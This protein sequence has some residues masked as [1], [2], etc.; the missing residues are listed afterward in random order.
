MLRWILRGLLVFALLLAAVAT[1]F[2]LASERRIQARQSVT[3]QPV[4]VPVDTL[5]IEKGRH[6]ATIRGC[7][8]CHSSDLGGRTFIDSP[9][10]GRISGTNLTRGKGGVGGTLQ[11][12]DWV[13]AIRHG[14]APDGRVLLIMPSHEYNV[15][16]DEDAGA[17]IAYLK[18]VP[19]VDRTLPDNSIALPLR[20]I[21]TVDA[22]VAL[23]PA[24]RIDHAIKPAQKIDPQD[25]IGF[26]KYLSSSCTGC[27][28]ADFSGGK[29]P[30]APPDWIAAANLTPGGNLKNW[31]LAQFSS[32][33]RTGKTPEGHQLDAHYMP[34][35]LLGQM[36]DQEMNA[37]WSYLQT[38]PVKLTKSH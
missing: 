37:I 18:S 27:H 33:M 3:P 7:V 8:E 20:V 14:I 24:E 5:S 22:E 28:R 21:A 1:T 6:L 32:A 10:A 30:G 26:G 13:R 36:T 9:M 11:D 23:I 29:I 2:Y 4:T 16:S 17:L 35:P 31:S 38:L 34:W 15:L 19:P 12:I 25:V